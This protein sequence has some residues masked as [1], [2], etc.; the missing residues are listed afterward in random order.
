MDR[1]PSVRPG[2]RSIAPRALRPPRDADGARTTAPWSAPLCGCCAPFW[3][4]RVVAYTFRPASGS[5]RSDRAASHDVTFSPH[6]VDARK[7]SAATAVSTGMSRAPPPHRQGTVRRGTFGGAMWEYEMLLAG[8]GP[9]RMSGVG[10]LRARRQHTWNI[11]APCRTW[12]VPRPGERTDCV[13]SGPRLSRPYRSS[14]ACTCGRWRGSTQRREMV[15]E[16]TSCA[17]WG[18]PGAGRATLLRASTVPCS[19]VCS[20]GST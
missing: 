4:Q 5:H 10:A 1:R 12:R 20:P 17:Q 18:R 6:P 13:S 3:Y 2:R 8:G 7:Q 15:S 19:A 9:S 14:C 11:L 16:S